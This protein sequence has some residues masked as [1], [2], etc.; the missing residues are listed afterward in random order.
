[1]NQ[2]RCE[3]CKNRECPLPKYYSDNSEKFET[4]L[5]YPL[6]EVV[7]CASHSDFQESTEWEIEKDKTDKFN[8]G[9]EFGIEFGRADEREIVLNK[10]ISGIERQRKD[11]LAY[12]QKVEALSLAIDVV[13]SFRKSK[14]ENE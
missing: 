1:M 11:I 8:S 14:Q 2:Y 7:G 12:P 3:T 13:E 9:V 4:G 5:M 6:S 10:I